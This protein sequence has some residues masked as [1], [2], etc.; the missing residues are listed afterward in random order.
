MV[1]PGRW[2]AGPGGRTLMLFDFPALG[3]PGGHKPWRDR[4]GGSLGFDPGAWIDSCCGENFAGG[5]WMKGQV[6]REH[7]GVLDSRA[8]F[9]WPSRGNM[10]VQLISFVY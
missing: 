6:T 5:L 4:L 3:V 9:C 1:R 7:P 2:L 8:A 10:G